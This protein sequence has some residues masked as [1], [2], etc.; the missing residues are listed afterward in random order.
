M[1]YPNCFDVSKFEDLYYFARC[2][3]SPNLSA[4]NFPPNFGDICV[5]RYMN[6]NDQLKKTSTV[7]YVDSAP[8]RRQI[9]GPIRETLFFRFSEGQRL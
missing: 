6:L 1:R 5:A 8:H 7:E 3:Y 9:Y 2:D 4:W